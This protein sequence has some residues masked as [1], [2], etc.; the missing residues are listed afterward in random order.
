MVTVVSQGQGP[1]VKHGSI[2][3]VAWRLKDTTTG[4]VLKMSNPKQ[5]ATWSITDPNAWHYSLIG[6]RQGS[7]VKLEADVHG[8]VGRDRDFNLPQAL[9]AILII[10]VEDSKTVYQRNLADQVSDNQQLEYVPSSNSRRSLYEAPKSTYR[11]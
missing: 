6:Q 7:T 3:T 5:S 4:K 9:Y 2:V 1:I 10:T 8:R 11:E